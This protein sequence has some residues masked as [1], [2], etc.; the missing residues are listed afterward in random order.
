MFIYC[1]FELKTFFVELWFGYHL[2]GGVPTS[3]SLGTLLLL[4]RLALLDDTMK[5][6]NIIVNVKWKSVNYS[7]VN[8][9][10]S[11]LPRRKY[12]TSHLF[13]SGHCSESARVESSRRSALLGNSLT[14]V[15]TIS[16]GINNIFERFEIS[17]I[18]L[19]VILKIE[20]NHNGNIFEM[21]FFDSLTQMFECQT[22]MILR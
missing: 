3:F 9:P 13:L 4:I 15:G 10:F 16:R 7:Q 18:N 21:W 11:A 6:R 1:T 14:L 12:L 2:W 5:C 20:G 8:C 22:L 19:F 17:E